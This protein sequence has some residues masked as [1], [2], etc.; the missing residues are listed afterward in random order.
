MKV[1]NSHIA[2]AVFFKIYHSGN[3]IAAAR[4]ASGIFQS[5]ISLGLDDTDS[6]ILSELEQFDCNYILT[7]KGFA[8][9][10]M[11]GKTEID[12]EKWHTLCREI[13]D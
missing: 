9:F 4:L 3:K 7:R 1:D 2:E 6:L 12:A 11:C 8:N 5:G 13:Y 10:S